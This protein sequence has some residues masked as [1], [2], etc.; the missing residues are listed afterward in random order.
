MKL[1]YFTASWCG[2]CQMMKPVWEQFIKQFNNQ[3]DIEK[4]DVDQNKQLSDRYSI[5]SVPT[6]LLLND[7]GTIVKRIQ[8]A[9]SLQSL[10][11]FVQ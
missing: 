11:N 4:V 9:Q 2:P 6:F 8:G 10:I 1:L 5:S 7:E 3:M